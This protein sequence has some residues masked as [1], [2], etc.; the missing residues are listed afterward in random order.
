[1][2]VTQSKYK[3]YEV[4]R[5]AILTNG[6]V[7]GTVLGLEDINLETN[8]ELILL[9]DFDIAALAS[10]TIKVEFSPDNV[11]YYQETVEDVNTTTG[12]ITERLATRDMTAGGQYRMAIPLM[13]KFIKISVLGTGVVAASSM[14]VIALVGNA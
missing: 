2:Y 10:G 13:D 6:Y 3:E 4:R 14:A 9:V 1:M 11:T 12:V 5:A 7:A 8:N